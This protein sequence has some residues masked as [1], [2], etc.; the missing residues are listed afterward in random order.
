MRMHRTESGYE[1]MSGYGEMLSLSFEMGHAIKK[2]GLKDQYLSDVHNSKRN[3]ISAHWGLENS[4]EKKAREFACQMDLLSRMDLN[5]KDGKKLL[6]K[7]QKLIDLGF[8]DQK[9]EVLK[10]TKFVGGPSFQQTWADIRD[11]KVGVM[12]TCKRV[13]AAQVDYIFG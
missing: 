4:S 9:G 2:T 13:I 12:E 3:V 11:P 10:D 7:R 8:M 5:S 1:L 6:P